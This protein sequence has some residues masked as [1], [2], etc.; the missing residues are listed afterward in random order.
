MERPEGAGASTDG[1][2]GQVADVVA[3]EF[4]GALAAQAGCGVVGEGGEAVELLEDAEE[5]VGGFEA[6]E[7]AEGLVV[8]VEAADDALGGVV[9][10]WDESSSFRYF[11]QPVASAG[12]R[13][14]SDLW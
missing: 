10:G 8:L 13:F 3:G 14:L 1:G 11:N 7:A 4:E 5:E 9:G 2:E 12:T 6:L